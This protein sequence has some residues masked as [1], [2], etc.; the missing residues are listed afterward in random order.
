MGE[1]NQYVPEE[2]E[3]SSASENGVVKSSAAWW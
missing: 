2:V 1:K 3:L